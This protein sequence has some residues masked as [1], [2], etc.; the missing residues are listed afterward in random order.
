MITFKP[1]KFYSH[2]HILYEFNKNSMGVSVLLIDKCVCLYNY[3]L[4]KLIYVLCYVKYERY[5]FNKIP[6]DE[7]IFC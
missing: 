1:D 4:I 3:I 6:A 5:E 2:S 7:N